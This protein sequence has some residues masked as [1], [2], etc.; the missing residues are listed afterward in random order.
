MRLASGPEKTAA[1]RK[2]NEMEKK[3][4]IAYFTATGRTRKVAE[5]MASAASSKGTVD[6]YEIKPKV[7][8]TRADLDWTDSEAR[9]S[10]EMHDMTSRPEIEDH[11]AHVEDYDVIFLGFPIWWHIAPTIINTFLE[12][13]DFSGKKVVLFA[14]SGGHP[15]GESWK[16]L[17]TSAD[18]TTKC[19]GEKLVRGESREDLAAW[20]NNM[21]I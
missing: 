2:E 18:Q 17:L 14:T 8:Y 7:P 11:D 16:Y 21:D 3:L 9:S 13:Y 19:I 4:L 12:S 10:I 5:V 20:I 6:I 1:G 15:M